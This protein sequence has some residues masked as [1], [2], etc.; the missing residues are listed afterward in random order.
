MTLCGGPVARY[1]AGPASL[2]WESQS[3]SDLKPTERP[4]KMPSGGLIVQQSQ[5]NQRVSDDLIQWLRELREIQLWM[6]SGTS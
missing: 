3:E 1:S 4:G 5:P 6:H 2:D